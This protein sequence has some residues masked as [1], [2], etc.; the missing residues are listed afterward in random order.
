ML[1]NPLL[2]T[3][4]FNFDNFAR[5]WN[6]GIRDYLGNSELL[7]TGS[8]APQIGVQMAGSVIAAIPLI[9]I[10]VVGM[11]SFIDGLFSGAIKL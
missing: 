8:S 4:P 10:F 7:S 3:L 5:A 1:T 2:P 6:S 11:R 9:L